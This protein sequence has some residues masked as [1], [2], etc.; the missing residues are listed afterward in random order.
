MIGR[1][2]R[3]NATLLYCQVPCGSRMVCTSAAQLS[4]QR[5]IIRVCKGPAYDPEEESRPI[6]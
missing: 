4:D 6:K 3:G 1:S 2:Q 5:S